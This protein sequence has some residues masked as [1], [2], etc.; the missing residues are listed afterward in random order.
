MHIMKLQEQYYSYIKNGT[1]I[2][3]IRLNDEKRRKIK[4][5]DYIEFQKEPNLEDKMILE[6]E[7]LLYFD[8]FNELFDNISIVELADSSISKEELKKDLELFYSKEKQDKYGV[9]AIKLK[10]DNK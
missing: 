4:I 1:K 9:V 8:N 7:D 6:V 3:E 2:Y 10:K 5:G